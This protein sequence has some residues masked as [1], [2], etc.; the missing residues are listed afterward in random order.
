MKVAYCTVHYNIQS[1]ATRLEECE[2]EEH[3]AGEIPNS[4]FTLQLHITLT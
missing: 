4:V 3:K 2:K 1:V